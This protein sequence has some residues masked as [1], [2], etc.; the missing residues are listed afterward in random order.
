[1]KKA[2]ARRWVPAYVKR[3]NRKYI[4]GV[5]EVGYG[6]WAGPLVVVAAAF[7]AEMAWPEHLGER[8]ICDSKRMKT[9]RRRLAV[10]PVI[11]HLCVARKLVEVESSTIDRL[12][13]VRALCGATRVAVYSC[14]EML[15]DEAS[16]IVDGDP[17][18]WSDQTFTYLAKGDTKV[19]AVAAASII[20][21]VHRDLLMIEL[22]KTHAGYALD[23]NM[24]YGTKEHREG[25]EK[26]GVCPLHRM[27]YRPMREMGH[28]DQ[29][30]AAG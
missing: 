14:R 12:T 15:D 1:M 23:K 26:L 27:S 6:A 4:I 22:S 28:G 20:A 17:L 5:D 30:R 16:V 7:P 19:H 3:S 10:L 2:A 9:H 21:K 25:L 24:G 29:G 8:D 18:R 13:G 11:E